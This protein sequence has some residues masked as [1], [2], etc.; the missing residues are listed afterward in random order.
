MTKYKLTYITISIYVQVFKRCECQVILPG[1]EVPKWLD[2]RK[3]EVCVLRLP[4]SKGDICELLIEIPRTLKW[5]KTGLLVCAVFEATQDCCGEWCFFDLRIRVNEVDM[6]KYALDEMDWDEDLD[7]PLGCYFTETGTEPS[8]HVWLK[9][10]P[11]NVDIKQE[12]DTKSDPSTPYLC[13]LTFFSEYCEGTFLFKSCGVHLAN[14]PYDDD[15]EEEEEEDYGYDD[16]EHYDEDNVISEDFEEAE[17]A[18]TVSAASVS[19]LS[20]TKRGLEHCDHDGEP[21]PTQRFK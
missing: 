4:D 13:R 18:I 9:Y 20:G 12:V 7:T 3:I 15:E 2:W 21:H 5:E 8:A 19:V 1:S 6:D 16:D 17:A 11:L 10:I 14:V